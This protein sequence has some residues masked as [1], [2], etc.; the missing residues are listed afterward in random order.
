VINRRASFKTFQLEVCAYLF[1]VEDDDLFLGLLPMLEIL[2]DAASRIDRDPI[3]TAEQ[4]EQMAKKDFAPLDYKIETPKVYSPSMFN[5]GCWMF[6]FYF[7][8]SFSV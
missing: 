7:C 6:I 5:V 2:D 4:M 1:K 3:K 8:L